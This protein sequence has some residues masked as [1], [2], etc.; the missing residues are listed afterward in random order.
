MAHTGPHSLSVCPGCWLGSSVPLH[1][2]SPEAGMSTV[3][4]SLLCQVP[5]LRR[6]EHLGLAR[7]PSPHGGLGVVRLLTR[8][9]YVTPVCFTSLVKTLI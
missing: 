7:H 1:V 2:T 3:A 4:S 8:Q 5:G 9:G 6:L